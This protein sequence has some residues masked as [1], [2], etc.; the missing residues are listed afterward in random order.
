M[1]AEDLSVPA[2]ELL[3]LGHYDKAPGYATRRPAGSPSWLLLWT[4]AG[5]GDVEQGGTS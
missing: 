5:E 3:I 4:E 1:T 2:A